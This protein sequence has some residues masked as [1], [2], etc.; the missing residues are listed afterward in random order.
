MSDIE[1]QRRWRLILGKEAEAPTSED[2]TGL[3]SLS[4]TDA[5][6]DHVLQALY[7]SDRKAG[8]G[9]SSPNVNRWL[10]DIRT[11]FPASVVRI[12]QKDAMDRLNL[13]KMLLE[14]ETL[15]F[16]VPD[17]HLIS[18]LIS[19]KNVIPQKTKATARKV[20]R[21]VVD[22]L[23]RKLQNP[24]LQ[25]VRGALS[26]ATRNARPR[27][28]E[29][30]WHRT[31]RKNLGNY[32]P[33]L[34]T[35]IAEKLVGYGRRQ[36][37]LRDVVLCVDQSGSMASSVVYA[38]ILAAVLATMRAVTAKLV[39]FDTAVVDLTPMLSDPVDVLFG[40]QLGGGTDINIAVTYC[41][42]L[43]T[44]PTQTV[45]ILVT[46]LFEGGD[47]AQLLKRLADTVR[48]GVS[49]ICLLA[50]SDEGMPSFEESLASGL[51]S[52]GIPCFACTPDLFPSLMATAL[53]RKDVSRWAARENIVLKGL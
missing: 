12:M 44:R 47:K 3:S 32:L 1:R 13:H 19:L 7:D 24:L 14:K 15:D 43:I 22:E 34:R 9:S 4:E 6:M 8:L 18:T 5:R 42:Q 21:Q 38:S 29:I 45:M 39:V 36:A 53:Q 41:Q 49:V 20:V 51:S 17:V 11:Y 10:G 27:G 52:L 26:R 16:V 28:H 48:S 23:E 33:E 31:I 46:D 35:I 40:T 37:S 50:L 30:N 25:A 2:G